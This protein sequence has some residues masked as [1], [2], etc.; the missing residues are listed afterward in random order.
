MN[1]EF[2]QLKQENDYGEKHLKEKDCKM[3]CSL[4]DA[5]SIARVGEVQREFIRK[6]LIGMADEAE[7]HGETLSETLGEEPNQWCDSVIAAG[8]R[9]PWWEG[10]LNVLYEMMQFSLF[11]SVWE[12]A[13]TAVYQRNIFVCNFVAWT[14][15]GALCS[16]FTNY[17]YPHFATKP[18]MRGVACFGIAVVS[19]FVFDHWLTKLGGPILPVKQWIVVVITAILFC[20]LWLV[21]RVNQTRE[22]HRQKNEEPDYAKIKS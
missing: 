17:I 16:C 21:R 2:R 7:H 6:D 20:L 10:L 22:Y 1:H 3:L 19:F 8:I 4:M 12:W 5:L 9:A 15:W 13:E 18:E 14:I 11:I